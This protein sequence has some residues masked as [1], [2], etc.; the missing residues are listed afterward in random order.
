MKISEIL[1]NELK[2]LDTNYYGGWISP[3]REVIYVEDE[4]GHDAVMKEY[5]LNLPQ[6][7]KDE[8]I[9]SG[10]L[11]PKASVY[12]NADRLGFVRFISK[13]M[14]TSFSVDGTSVALKKTYNAWAA[15]ALTADIVRIYDKKQDRTFMLP[16]DKAKLINFIQN[17]PSNG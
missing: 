9:K 8:L 5:L 6:E 7:T 13:E 12:T 1:V 14:P 4:Y 16:Q 17:I 2:T 10:L 3:K 11:N 15:T